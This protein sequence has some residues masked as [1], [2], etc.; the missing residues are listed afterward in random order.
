VALAEPDVLLG[1]Q[2]DERLKLIEL[3]LLRADDVG[4]GAAD[5]L[6]SDGQAFGHGMAV[7]GGIA[8]VE[9]HDLEF[10]HGSIIP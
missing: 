8:E 2:R 1:Q 6:R 5:E 9:A 10:A 4:V 3:T 7:H